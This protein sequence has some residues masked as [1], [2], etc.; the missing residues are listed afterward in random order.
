MAISRL[1]IRFARTV[2]D[3]VSIA[4]YF[5]LGDNPLVKG[6]LGNTWSGIYD[7]VQ[8]FDQNP[9]QFAGDLA[10]GGFGQGLLPG[11]G[12]LGGGLLAQGKI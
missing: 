8:D 10:L 4:G 7:T 6:A 3:E 5:D 2:A 1:A 12:L 9:L 11:G